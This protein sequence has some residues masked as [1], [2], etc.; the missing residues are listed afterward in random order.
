ML[1][2]LLC[3]HSHLLGWRKKKTK[4]SSTWNKKRWAAK[5]AAGWQIQM[6]PPPPLP[7]LPLPPP[8]TI[9]HPQKPAR[10]ASR[11]QAQPGQVYLPCDCLLITLLRININKIYLVGKRVGRIPFEFAFVGHSQH[12]VLYSEQY[13]APGPHTERVSPVHRECENCCCVSN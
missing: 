6:P 8:L 13:L 7:L 4:M 10:I 1:L 9:I 3:L 12:I 5:A 11:C 2:L